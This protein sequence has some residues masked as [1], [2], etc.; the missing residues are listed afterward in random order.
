MSHRQGHLAQTSRLILQWTRGAREKACAGT[1]SSN[2]SLHALDFQPELS[3]WR[4]IF[5]SRPAHERTQMRQPAA[6]RRPGLAC[7]ATL[8][9]GREGGHPFS[10]AHIEP[11]H[12]VWGGLSANPAVR[13]L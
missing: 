4:M 12:I 2:E 13:L 10:P 7:A 5:R 3:K 6:C 11:E 1:S 8:K 9:T